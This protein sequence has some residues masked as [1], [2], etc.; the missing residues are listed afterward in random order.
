MRR[1][2]RGKDSIAVSG[3]KDASKVILSARGTYGSMDG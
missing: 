3:V 1:G 2:S